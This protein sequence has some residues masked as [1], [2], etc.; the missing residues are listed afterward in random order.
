MAV[1]VPVSETEIACDGLCVPVGLGLEER[2]YVGVAGDGV[3]VKTRV[4]E[5]VPVRVGDGVTLPLGSK[6]RV[7][8]QDSEWVVVVEGA[9]VDVTERLVGVRLGVGEKDNV[10]DWGDTLC[11]HVTV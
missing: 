3:A 7:S 8:V 6:L 5:T 1:R 11:T 10:G 9:C 2:G 4:G